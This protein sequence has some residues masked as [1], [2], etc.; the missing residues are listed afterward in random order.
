MPDQ[1]SGGVRLSAGG[2]VGVGTA[3]RQHGGGGFD[4]LGGERGDARDRAEGR[5]DGV[6][7]VAGAAG[8]SVGDQHADAP[9]PCQH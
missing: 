9:G 6:R 2:A 4:D 3:E 5:R 8:V 1:G 7:R